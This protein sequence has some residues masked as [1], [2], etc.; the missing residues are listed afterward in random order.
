MAL[1]GGS[2]YSKYIQWNTLRIIQRM[3][4]SPI[5]CLWLRSIQNFALKTYIRILDG[6]FWVLQRFQSIIYRNRYSDEMSALN[7]LLF[8]FPKKFVDNPRLP[9]GLTKRNQ[10]TTQKRLDLLAVTNLLQATHLDQKSHYN[11]LLLKTAHF[12]DWKK[13]IK[14]TRS[15]L[16]FLLT[17]K[18]K[19][20]LKKARDK[21]KNAVD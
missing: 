19:N 4:M 7:T 10:L 5:F 3:F 16:Q 20:Y 18:Q 12:N 9:M 8:C 17:I 13:S 1:L 2:F 14:N 11:L 6:E 15:V 21:R